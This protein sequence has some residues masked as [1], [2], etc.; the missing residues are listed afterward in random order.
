MISIIIPTYNNE[1]YLFN[2]LESVLNQTSKNWEC[3]IIDDG[4]D[5][6]TK[7]IIQSYRKKDKR[8]HSYERPQ[9]ILK[10]ANACR[11]IGIENAEG[12]FLM[13]LD[14]DDLLANTCIENRLNQ[15]DKN[16]AF[17]IFPMGVLRDS[18]FT[19]IKI[20]N[21]YAG[22]DESYLSMFLSYQI[23]WPI[24]SLLLPKANLS[25]MFSEKLQRFQDVDFSIRLLLNTA[26][27]QIKFCKVEPD[28]FYR[29]DE[30]NLMKFN[31]Q[32]FISKIVTSFSILVLDLIPIL[33]SK[34]DKHHIKLLSKFYKKYMIDI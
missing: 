16:S 33:K 18:D 30:K 23:P 26:E 9:H 15:I 34:S 3:I 29:K 8:F 25:I 24:T 17:F 31:D 6:G 4:S 10:G 13:F 20:I 5:D 21:R 28:C 11:N 32:L 12:A 14:A 22:V 1:N 7:E 2:T 27:E 19:N